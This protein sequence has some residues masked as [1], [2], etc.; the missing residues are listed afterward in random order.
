VEG[1]TGSLGSEMTNSTTHIY[2]NPIRT[3]RVNDFEQF[4]EVVKVAVDAQRP[5][6]SNRWQVLR[7]TG[8]GEAAAGV[9]TYAFIFDGGDLD[10]DWELSVLL[11]AHYGAEEAERLMSEA[12][13]TFATFQDW[14]AGLGEHDDEFPQVGW[15]FESCS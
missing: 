8:P 11:P 13:G 6:L 3:D 9:T 7:A 10:T 4:L 12:A 1:A 2:L 14:V 5:D 15:T